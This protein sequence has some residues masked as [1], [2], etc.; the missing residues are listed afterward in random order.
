MRRLAPALL[1]LG[2]ATGL[3]APVTARTETGSFAVHVGGIRVGTLGYAFS[4]EGKNYRV[5]AR[6][7]A[8]GLA[9]V[10]YEVAYVT[11]AA[12]RVS[13][14]RYV[15]RFYREER[16]GRDNTE[17]AEIPFRSGVPLPKTYE[18]PRGPEDL[19]LDPAD[20]RGTVDPMTAAFAIMRD[21][22]TADLCSLDLQV[23]DGERRGRIRLSGPRSDGEARICDGVFER[24]AGY[25]REDLREQ[26]EFPFAVHY[27]PIGQGWW[28]MISAD[29]PSTA[30]R[31][32][33]RRQ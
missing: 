27:A 11:D 15:P 21:T 31:V 12:G 8:S 20:Q 3:A 22:R 1:V 19:P 14:G 13:G 33:M 29:A 7:V 16:I 30:G 28:Q 18:P 32:I 6:A 25:T 17:S 9:R 2:L 26:R 4:I 24:V 10:F 23:W 5:R